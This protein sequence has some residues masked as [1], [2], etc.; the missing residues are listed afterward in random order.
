MKSVP[1][2]RDLLGHL[3]GGP[4]AEVMTVVRP[5]SWID[6]SMLR[7]IP[8][9][10]TRNGCLTEGTARVNSA[11]GEIQLF[12]A[13]KPGILKVVSMSFSRASRAGAEGR[14]VE[15]IETSKLGFPDFGAVAG[16]VRRDSV[17]G[18][19]GS[20]CFAIRG[21]NLKLSF[22][23]SIKTLARAGFRAGLY[24][25]ARAKFIRSQ[26]PAA[27]RPSSVQ[28][29]AISADGRGRSRFRRDCRDCGI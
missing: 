23:A 25:A 7:S 15:L 5:N 13:A 2:V 3:Y 1:F 22:K 29:Q 21:L 18:T 17:V 27:W 20:Q 24:R 6:Y 11:S 19:S 9:S 8:V 14:A 26:S 4:F 28:Q 10:N 12:V 16:R